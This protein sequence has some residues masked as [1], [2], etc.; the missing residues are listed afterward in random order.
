MPKKA[1]SKRKDRGPAP[2]W[3][4]AVLLGLEIVREYVTK[5]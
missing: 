5:K 3:Y 2:W 4:G 1:T